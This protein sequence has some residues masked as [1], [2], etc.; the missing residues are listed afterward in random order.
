MEMLL[1]ARGKSCESLHYDSYN[2]NRLINHVEEHGVYVAHF[3]DCNTGKLLPVHICKQVANVLD[4]YP[5]DLKSYE[6]LTDSQDE[7]EAET[8]IPYDEQIEIWRRFANNGG[9]T[10]E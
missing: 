2:W 4:K 6:P 5:I 7:Q 3:D 8:E 10:Q 9:C 1:L